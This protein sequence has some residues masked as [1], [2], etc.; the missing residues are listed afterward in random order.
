MVAG[1]MLAMPVK[2]EFERLCLTKS[3]LQFTLSR[4]KAQDLLKKSLTINFVGLIFPKRDK[5]VFQWKYHVVATAK[6]KGCRRAASFHHR[7][8]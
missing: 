5:T 8:L 2:I 7:C 3:Q 4:T 1:T 6:T